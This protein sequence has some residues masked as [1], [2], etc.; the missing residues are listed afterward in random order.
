MTLSAALTTWSGLPAFVALIEAIS[1]GNTDS[2]AARFS[3]TRTSPLLG[4]RLSCWRIISG[5][6]A[7]P[8]SIRLRSSM[9]ACTSSSFGGSSGFHY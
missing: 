8:A 3:R 9:R 2:K 4:A 1:S 7:V 6:A 5:N